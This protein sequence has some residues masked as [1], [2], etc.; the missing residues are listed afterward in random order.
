[1]E[2]RRRRRRIPR[3]SEEARWEIRHGVRTDQTVYPVRALLAW[4]HRDRR[5]HILVGDDQNAK[6]LERF[7]EQTLEFLRTTFPGNWYQLVFWGEADESGLH[8][9]AEEASRAVM[10]GERVPYELCRVSCA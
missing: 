1:M 10:P 6:A 2:E 5:L 4:D 8:L 7:A 9:L 3:R